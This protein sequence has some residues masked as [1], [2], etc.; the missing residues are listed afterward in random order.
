MT[1]NVRCVIDSI[2]LV[3]C[4]A[5]AAQSPTSIEDI[6]VFFSRLFSSACW[7]LCLLDTPHLC[8]LTCNR[9]SKAL[10]GCRVL[11][12]WCFIANLVTSLNVLVY[13]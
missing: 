7:A 10:A 11:L 5:I 2:A 8:E 3:R 1:Q 9:F 4:A 13:A 12:C 6:I